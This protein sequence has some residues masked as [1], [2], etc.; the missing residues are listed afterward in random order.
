MGAAAAM[1]LAVVG[2][3]VP[4]GA[5]ADTDEGDSFDTLA[6]ATVEENDDV[7]AVGK[8]ASGQTVVFTTDA[9]AQIRG[10]LAH[11]D[12]I[13][14]TLDEPLTAYAVGNVV[15][16]G[17]YLADDGSAGVVCSIGFTGWSPDGEPAVITAGHCTGDG[18][19]TAAQRT[20]PTGDPAG[21]GADDNTDVEA[22]DALGGFGFWQFGGPGDDP[23]EVEDPNSV[24][25]AVID[26]E[27]DDLTLL[28][29]VT[30]WSTA[31]DD[32]LSLS[33]SLVTSTGPV[34]GG[35]VAKSGR[36]T[37]HTTGEV[38][39]VDG[40]M[41]IG[42][43]DNPEDL[44][45][46]HGFGAFLEADSGDSGGAMVQGETAVGILSGGGIVD[47]Q[48][49]VWGAHLEASLELTDGYTVALHIDAP[50][51]TSPDDGDT[52]GA[53]GTIS[54]TGVAG[55]TL[56]VT[57]EDG[58]EFETEIDSDGNW[59]F[60]AP[61]DLGE[62]EFAIHSYQGFDESVQ[63][64]YTLEVIPAAPAF[65]SPEN[66]EEFVTEITEITGTGDAGGT[67]ELTGAVSAEVEIGADGTW[68]V[69]AELG[70]GAYSLTATQ[71]VEGLES[72][73]A[74]VEFSVVPA[75]PEVT[76]PSD[77]ATFGHDE[78][79]TSASGTGTP[80]ANINADLGG[81]TLDGT[82]NEDGEWVLEFG[83]ALEPGEYT[84]EVTQEVNGQT[85]ATASVS[86]VVES[87]PAP[88][89]SDPEP[90]PDPEEPGKDLPATG[91]DGSYLPPAVASVLMLLAG[92]GLLLARRVGSLG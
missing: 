64:T 82:V 6:M 75:A 67:L 81:T 86:F 10:P 92:A 71:T 91:L 52:V 47:G 85:S 36:T 60:P 68:S 35:A 12:V 63:N 41:Q 25:I 34:Q 20:L 37:G 77:D 22:V 33:T 72:A 51:L 31:E 32:D 90:T 17:G 13:T 40:W 7:Q 42:D 11:T 4:V 38:D 44:R 62:F 19:F 46:V 23:G 59:S 5:M 57:P 43:P 79:P 55:T 76:A 87:A 1:S 84:L 73:E 53:G 83:E 48:P 21:G 14:R 9:D 74:S 54:G 88:S 61:E 70:P 27:N 45:W 30:D 78:A 89:P 24:D 28:P 65:T 66:G 49:F 18:D 8:N 16:G 15:G 29:E 69:E 3:L 26:V 2:V 39:I 80:G 56:V 50:G 58:E